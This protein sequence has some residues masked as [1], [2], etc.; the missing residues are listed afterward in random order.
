[1]STPGHVQLM[2]ARERQ[3]A[4]LLAEVGVRSIA[5]LHRLVEGK[6]PGLVDRVTIHRYLF[7]PPQRLDFRVV[8]ALAE[9]LGREVEQMYEMISTKHDTARKLSR[10]DR[11]TPVPSSGVALAAV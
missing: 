2:N 1:M 7:R 11:V 9:A 3:V 8:Q 5:D 4:L 10:P 6:H